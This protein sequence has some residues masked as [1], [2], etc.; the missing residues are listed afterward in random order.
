MI[1]T[2]DVAI[3]GSGIVGL[4]HAYMALRRGLRVVLFERDEFAVGASVRNFGLVWPIGQEPG[5]GLERALR[6]RAHWQEIAERAGIWCNPNG[7]LHLAYAED[8]LAVLEEFVTRNSNSGYQ[9]E[10]ISAA[11][12][13]RKSPAI[14]Q[15]GLRGALWSTTEMTVYSREA[16]RKLPIWLEEK[17]GLVRRFNQL[18]TEIHL[19]EI[20]AGRETWEV[21]RV[22]VCSGPEFQSLYPQAY[23]QA[24][25]T[26]CKLQ[27]MKLIPREPISWGPSLCAGLTLGHYAAFSSCVALPAVL[28][29]FDRENPQLRENGIHILVSQTPAGELIVG[30][31]HQYGLTHEPFDAEKINQLILEYLNRFLPLSDYHVAERWHGIY[32]KCEGQ[33][34]VVMEPT[35][36]VQLVNGLG[37]A[38][39]TLSFGLAEEVVGRW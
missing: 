24:N 23:A 39:M 19:P 36:G 29:R 14:R 26:K 15:E 11:E 16:I 31:S 10:L 5:K 8:E 37:G 4:A 13:V 21:D 18:I 27:M 9:C 32:P 25:L 3:V 28:A 6:S 35:P 7:S 2:A 30:D 17:M 38:G 1:K 34:H 22:V 33:L 20:H 12:A